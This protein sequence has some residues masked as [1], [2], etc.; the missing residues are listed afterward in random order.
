M[1]LGVVFAS[2]GGPKILRAIRSFRKM[3]P[4]LPVH[5][6]FDIDSNT[7]KDKGYKALTVL[8]EGFSEKFVGIKVFCLQGNKAHINGTLNQGMKWLRELGYSHVGL[9]HDDLIFSPLLENQFYISKCIQRMEHSSELMASSGIGFGDLE[10]LY[11]NPGTVRFQPGHWDAPPEVW[12]SMD[13]ESEELWQKLCP[14]GIPARISEFFMFFVDYTEP[15]SLVGHCCRLGPVGQIVPLWAW[16]AVGG[17]DETYGVHYDSDY[18]AAC[19]VKQLPPVLCFPNS[20]ILHLHNQSIGYKDPS[21]NL[22]GDVTAAFQKKYNK[23]YG[24]FWREQEFYK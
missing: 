14:Q 20:P 18:P 16:E 9:F 17:F 13:L 1:R 23:E 10:T 15:G 19:L 24:Q 4:D 8:E 7:W 11:R 2:T 22:W 3:E 6:V 21:V 12:D 5:V